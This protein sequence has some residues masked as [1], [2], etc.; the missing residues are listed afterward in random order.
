[1]HCSDID[2]RAALF[3]ALFSPMQN[4]L[5]LGISHLFSLKV[6]FPPFFWA[7]SHTIPIA[8]TFSEALTDR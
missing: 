6:I 1:M 4:L 2:A 5:S 7:A 3:P 8:L